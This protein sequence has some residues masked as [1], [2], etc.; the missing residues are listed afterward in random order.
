MTTTSREPFRPT[1][2]DDACYMERVTFADGRTGK[3]KVFAGRVVRARIETMEYTD[4]GEEPTYGEVTQDP[5]TGVIT[6][7]S[8]THTATWSPITGEEA[9]VIRRQ[10]AERRRAMW[11]VIASVG[12]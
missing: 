5:Q 8:S 9:A 6:G 10:A 1:I 11:E 12:A 2:D 4:S 3:A 7:V